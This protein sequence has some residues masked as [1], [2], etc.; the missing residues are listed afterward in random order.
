MTIVSVIIPY[1]QERTGI[2]HRCLTS[3]FQQQLPPDV[4]L[5]VIVVDDGS[6][7]PAR[8]EVTAF[9]VAD[10]FDMTIVE[11]PNG[12]VAA[13]RNTGLSH[14]P[15]TATYIA[16][17]DSDDMWEPTHLIKAI[18]ALDRGYDFYFCDS[19][20]LGQPYTSFSEKLFSDTF[21]SKHSRD[22]G[23]GIYELDCPRFFEQSLRGRVFLTP[24]VVYRRSV[25]PDLA[26]DT[27][28]RI[29]GE[30]CLFFFQLI[31]KCRRI[32]C[33]SDLMVKCAD[34]VNI[35]AGKFGW[36]DPGHLLRHMGQILA[37]YRFRDKLS[38]SAPDDAFLSHRIRKLRAL[39]AF[40][41]IRYF[42]KKRETWPK[43]LRDMVRSD[44]WFPIWYPLYGLYVAACFPLRL[45]DPLKTW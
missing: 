20:R 18:S 19:E 17:L 2:L 3:V 32:C 37:C 25:A 22:I 21:L 1:F 4:R 41:T 40:F 39:F 13:A 33:C 5:N 45:Y 23:G 38:L 12:G 31:Q 24:T 9:N 8:T 7:I 30:D 34:G 15:K 36:D 42:L 11:Q 29:A 27:S 26:F 10:P 28:L 14:V 43:E 44:R 35:H 16:F 6:P